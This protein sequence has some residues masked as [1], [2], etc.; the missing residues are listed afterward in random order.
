MTLK[1]YQEKVLDWLRRYYERCRVLQEAGD[2]FP[3]ATAF[4]SITAEIYGSG[5]PYSK[6]DQLPGIPYV[7]LRIPTGGGKTVVGCEAIAVAQTELL[8]ADRSLVLWL[9]PSDPIRRQTLDRLKDRKDPYRVALDTKLGAVEVLDI[10]EALTMTRATL[11]GATVVVVATMQ[12]FRRKDTSQLKVYENNGA[13]MS[14]FE[15]LPSELL[16]VLE[17]NL[18]G[19]FDYS[20]ANVFR[21]RRPF[22]IVD[23]AHN[24][25]QPL[26]FE[27]LRRL[28]P[29]GILELTATPNTKRETVTYEGEK[30][31]NP[32]SNVLCSV[33]AYA[34]KAEEM[35]K[36]PI[37]LRYREPW[38]ALLG[39]AI[40]L[41]N[42]L[43]EEAEK[44]RAEAG[45]GANYLR[46]IM[47]L[48]AQPEYQDKAS[49]TVGQLEQ[50]LLEQWRIPPEQ[51]AV[52]TGERR[53]LDK[54]EN[55]N[56]L[57]P[58]CKLRFIITVQ[59]LKEGWDCPFA[60]VLFSVA[61]LSSGRAVEQILGRIMRMPYARRQRREPLNGS[62]AFVASTRFDAAA[63]ALKDGLVEAGFEKQEAADLVV[64]PTLA[65][66]ATT[67]PIPPSEPVTVTL[68]SAPAGALP[69]SVV[70]AVTWEP[71][72]KTLCIERPLTEKQETALVAAFGDEKTKNVVAEAIRR[73]AG[74]PAAVVARP[75][76]P[77]QRGMVFEVPVLALKQGDFLRRFEADDLDDHVAWS[78]SESD[79]ELSGF[80]IPTEQRGIKIDITD[81]E[82]LQ[83]DFIPVNDAQQQL[84]A[85]SAAW[86]VGKLVD[87]LDRSFAHPDLTEAETGIWLTRA[88]GKLVDE[89]KFT[90]ERL[91]AHRHRLARA[92][93]EKLRILRRE[94]RRVAQEELLFTDASGAVFVSAA[95][96]HR[97]HPS[98]YPYTFRYTGLELPRHYYEVI[99]DL[100][101]SGEEYE[102]ARVIAQLS[103][104]EFWVR[105]LDTEPESS[106]WI[107]TSS[108]K[109]YPDFV[110]RLRN[111]KT[112]AIEYKGL[113]RA[114]NDDTKEKERLGELWQARSHGECLFVM[115]KSPS[116]L[117]R[118]QAMARLAC[119]PLS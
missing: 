87:W 92:V 83:Q 60:Y 72:A 117:G 56:M 19:N 6:V 18:E 45:A 27:T 94:A 84:L 81:A 88:A 23:E 107:Q 54:P 26:A 28:N 16:A 66:A 37:Y 98:K 90:P 96:T 82:R 112:L 118:V 100:K 65:L 2:G 58:D 30:V 31:E 29:S 105:N 64:E 79:A 108:D 9:V 32:P 91:T 22:V 93:A 73:R 5:L 33:S 99:G 12:A 48:Q 20:L 43:K 50:A 13:L 78:L 44:E 40:G 11:D 1:H 55:A 76:S 89:R 25:R 103:E 113:D 42:E 62:Y 75:L 109:F 69:L 34:L 8:R 110:C 97:F 80:Q 17:R 115:V 46:P 51:V 39:D 63:R 53:D 47:L 95:A 7:C 3:V 57:S 59:A 52:H 114:T 10:E 14:H 15:N 106:F 68:P 77:S 86:P 119:P 104:V 116:E 41:L 74:R 36:L 38:D 21:L 61:E 4:T 70:D 71:A 67:R 102:C 35:I 111:G 85:A 101:N 24:A 49:I